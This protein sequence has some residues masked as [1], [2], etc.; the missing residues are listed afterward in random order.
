MKKILVM[1]L[2][3][4][5]IISTASAWDCSWAVKEENN[6]MTSDYYCRRVVTLQ[7]TRTLDEIAIKT[8]TYISTMNDPGKSDMFQKLMEHAEQCFQTCK[9]KNT[10]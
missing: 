4:G 6:T 2:L 1:V 10:Y 3:L 9:L 8:G 5:S 7:T